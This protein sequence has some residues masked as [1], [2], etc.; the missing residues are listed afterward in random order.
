[1]EQPKKAHRLLLDLFNN[2]APTP[3]QI[4]L[5]ALAA[6]AA[7][8]AGD[9]YSYMAEFHLANG[10]LNLATTQLDLALASPGLTDVQ[11]KR[12]RA[13]RDE[14]ADVLRDQPRRRPPE[15]NSLSFAPARR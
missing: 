3:E 11:R 10:D 14:I 8:D 9:A 5:I 4:R 7:G 1:M 13:R 12:F 6:S 2:V 15:D